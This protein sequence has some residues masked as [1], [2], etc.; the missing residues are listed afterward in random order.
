MGPL[1]ETGKKSSGALVGKTLAV[2]GG[3]RESV[4]GI[5]IAKQLGM[6]VLLSDLD[7]QCPGAR[8]DVRFVTAS[9]YDPE[10]TISKIRQS[11]IQ[12]DG[13][14]SMA[15]DVPYTVS[16][17]A[18][19]LGLRSI[20]LESALALSC[21]IKMKDVLASNSIPIP[22]YREVNSREELESFRASSSS[23]LILKP[24]D[25]RG[26]RGV[27]RLLSTVDS[28]WAFE[29]SKRHSPSGRLILEEFL[30]GPQLSSES[31]I[32]DGK[33][34]TVGLA[35]RNYEDLNRFGPYVVEDG[36]QL[37]AELDAAV[38]LEIDILLASVVSAFELENCT[39]KGDLVL[40]DGRPTVIEVAPRLSGG[41]FSSH[42][43]PISTGVEFIRY[44]IEIA[45]GN[46]PDLPTE[47]DFRQEH[48]AQRFLFPAPGRVTSV[49]GVSQVSSLSF[50][51]LCEVYVSP[52]D[53]VPS[54]ENHP[55]R[56]GMVITSGATRSQAVS[57]AKS[58]VSQIEVVTAPL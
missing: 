8:E 37:P 9:T 33:V 17:V 39:L 51:E 41:L 40:H 31:I 49:S 30:E 54:T 53:V 13:V 7:P 5:R 45:V 47:T 42:S 32:S 12:V 27:V 14:M 58:A 29:E 2:I 24:A 23:S 15:A 28:G 4:H 18:D 6:N 46:N 10:S 21:K 50:V 19:A 36:G 11:G 20:P 57:R 55:A 48:V 35:D 22:W 56:A 1:T 34:V 3:G 26:S 43:I 44:A 25:S 38:R 52:G 16:R